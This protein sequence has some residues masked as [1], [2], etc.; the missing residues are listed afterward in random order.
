LSLQCQRDAS[1]SAKLWQ[2]ANG[3]D[4]KVSSFNAY[5][6]NGYRF[7]TT[8]YKQSQPNPRTTNTGVFTPDTD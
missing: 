2:V 4:Y 3:F 5:D 6:V 1:I 8:R 7:H